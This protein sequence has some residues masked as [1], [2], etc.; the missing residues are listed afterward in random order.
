M[1]QDVDLIVTCNH[2]NCPYNHE[3]E[4]GKDVLFMDDPE[5]MAQTESKE[6]NDRE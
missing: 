5:C 4:C 3:K 6:N 1:S 2:E